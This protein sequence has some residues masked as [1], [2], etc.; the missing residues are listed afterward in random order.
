MTLVAGVDEAGRGPV[1]GPLVVAGV[2][3]LD[4]QIPILRGMGVRDSK[5]LTPARRLL[6]SD[7]IRKM[8]VGHAYVELDP[9]EIDRVVL[10]GKRLNRLNF[11][12]AKAMA[13]VIRRLS[14]E[15]AYVDAADVIEE[16][17]GRKIKDELS[18]NVEVISEHKADVR[19]P[20][21]SAASI[22][23]KV[24]RDEVVARLREK[25]G[26]FGSGY[27]N[28]PITRQFLIDCIRKHD[29]LPPFVRKSWK[30]IKRLKEETGQ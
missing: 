23:A 4:Y 12:V 14:P 11:A 6:L 26:D 17:F 20:V 2:M 1:I 24:R 5:R 3:F 7:E 15:V 19:Y 27:P 9:D 13:E 28:D 29:S 18:F 21:V 25:F 22:I 8:A 30:T 16:R 10:T